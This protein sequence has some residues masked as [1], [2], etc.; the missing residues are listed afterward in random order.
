[1]SLHHRFATFALLAF[2]TT[3]LACG[4]S[5]DGEAT[6][7]LTPAGECNALVNVASEVPIVRE[8]TLPPPPAGGAITDGTY[9]VTRATLHTGPNGAT[10]PHGSVKMTVA[11]AGTKGESVFDGVT[12]S[13]HFTIVGNEMHA[14][15]I[16]PSQG[17]DT[18]GFTA[19]PDSLTIYLLD[20]AGTRVYLLEKR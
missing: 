11:I 15:N 6:P 5:A 18:V 1:M 13:M 17:T 10:G 19:R 7:S 16:C 12:R 8:A 2:T 9:V 3:T 20:S 4:G 14:T